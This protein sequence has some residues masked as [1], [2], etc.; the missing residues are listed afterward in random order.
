MK[1]YWKKFKAFWKELGN[2]LTNIACPF[3]SV[4]VAILE[5]FGAPSSW[6]KNVKKAEY[7]C[8]QACGT[9][10]IIDDIVEVIDENI[11]ENNED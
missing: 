9:K 11:G 1:T 10:E 2:L 5:I 6:I 4:G 3:L 8:W 7:W